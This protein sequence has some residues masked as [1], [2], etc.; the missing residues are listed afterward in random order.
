MVSLSFREL[1]KPLGFWL[2]RGGFSLSLPLSLLDRETTSLENRALGAPEEWRRLEKYPDYEVSN[3]GRVRRSSYTYTVVVPAQVLTQYPI[4]HNPKIQYRGVRI[5]KTYKRVH[6]LVMYA[7]KGPCPSGK[8][9]SHENHDP[10]DNRLENLSYVTHS[11][12]M[13]HS[14]KSGRIPEKCL[15]NLVLGRVQR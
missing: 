13:R 14:Y 9:V 6:R 3:L 1:G 4:G 11:E 12:N 5:G 15:N 2:G 7:F 10:S 8:E